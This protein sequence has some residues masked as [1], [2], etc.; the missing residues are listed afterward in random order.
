[1][2]KAFILAAF[3]LM[4]CSG[5]ATVGVQESTIRPEQIP[6]TQ[7]ETPLILQ[8]QGKGIGYYYRYKASFYS[9]SQYFIAAISGKYAVPPSSESYIDVSP[10]FNQAVVT[11]A[12]LAFKGIIIED[13]QGRKGPSPNYKLQAILQNARMVPEVIQEGV[14]Y[15]EKPHIVIS[16]YAELLDRTEHL[17]ASKEAE[18]KG[19]S[20]GIACNK[21]G[22]EII[23]WAKAEIDKLAVKR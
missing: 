1:M 17:L 16:Y 2:R 5:C 8:T 3:L 4:L 11:G 12:K 6:G 15:P 9:E 18:V 14:H 13:N 21:A 7:N 19:D 10:F 23:N 22:L 20:P